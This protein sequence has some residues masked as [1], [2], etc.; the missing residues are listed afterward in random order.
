V[1]GGVTTLVDMPLNSSPP[2][3][4]VANFEVKREA[5]RGQCWS[6]IAFWGGCVPNNEVMD[7][8]FLFLFLLKFIIVGFV[9]PFDRPYRCWSQRV[10]MF[11]YRQW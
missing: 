10:Q 1:S 7:V 3:T 8:S 11:S 2:T 4:T 5:A 9:G 6:D